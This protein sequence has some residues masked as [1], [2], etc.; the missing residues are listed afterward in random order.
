MPS[1]R[2]PVYLRGMA[3]RGSEAGADDGSTAGEVGAVG[4]A[5]Q[6]AGN[7][8]RLRRERSWSLEELSNRAGVSRAMLSQVE[9]GKTTPTIAVL[10]KIATGFG[11][12]FAELLR[13]DAAADVVVV[14]AGQAVAIT[15]ADR[16]F[17]SIPLVPPGSMPGVELYRITVDPGG[18]SHSPPHAT[19][20]TEVVVVEKGKLRLNVGDREVTLDAGDAACFPADVEHAYTAVGDSACVLHDLVRYTNGAPAAAAPRKGASARARRKGA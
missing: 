16:K 7:L 20:T 4:F 8:R 9:T 11:V 14:R 5:R 15:S 12:Q 6:V 17:R 10:W 3:R 13:A 1:A 19:G 2:A 18:S